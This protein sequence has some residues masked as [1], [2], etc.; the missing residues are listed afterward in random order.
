MCRAFVVVSDRLS[1]CTRR[2]GVKGQ[3]QSVLV[4]E[5]HGSSTS[6]AER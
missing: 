4:L 2:C 5:R 6:R 3:S 1:V